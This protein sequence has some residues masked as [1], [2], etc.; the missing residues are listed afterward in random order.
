MSEEIVELIIIPAAVL[1]PLTLVDTGMG[2]LFIVLAIRS[3]DHDTLFRSMTFLFGS[4]LLIS[5][6]YVST[7]SITSFIHRIMPFFS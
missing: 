5:G 2:I 4:F 1:L 6:L 7:L 3:I